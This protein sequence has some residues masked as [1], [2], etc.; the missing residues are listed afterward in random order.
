MIID[1][2]THAFP[3]AI[4][5]ARE[6]FFG[7]EPAFKM[8]YESPKSKLVGVSETI[9]MMDD[10]GIDKSVVFGFPWRSADPQLSRL[11]LRYC[12]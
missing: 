1:I 6:N 5:Q 3:P 10:Q 11:A 9:A 7:S 8:L 4:R 12:I 2:H